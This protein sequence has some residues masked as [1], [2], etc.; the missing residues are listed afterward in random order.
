MTARLWSPPACIGVSD[1]FD[2]ADSD[3]QIACFHHMA[4]DTAM[5][6]EWESAEIVRSDIEA[7]LTKDVRL[8][9]DERQVRRYLD[10]PLDTPFPLEYAYALLG[11]VRGRTVLDFGCG[12]GQNSL[13]LAR[14]GARVVGVVSRRR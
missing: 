6:R 12:S 8:V 7:T 4:P 14:R 10:P 3:V 2:T 11:D 5:K 1:A 13:L 9:A